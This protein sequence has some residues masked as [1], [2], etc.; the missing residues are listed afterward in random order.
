MANNFKFH[1]GNWRHGVS[2]STFDSEKLQEH[3]TK[4]STQSRLN[5]LVI[6]DS[7]VGKSTWINA[8][9]N[10]VT[11]EDLEEAKKM[12]LQYV[13]PLRFTAYNERREK[14]LIQIG[15]SENEGRIEG[16][17]ATQKPREHNF[18]H[19]GKKV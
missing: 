3:L 11:F 15:E 6:G 7:G 9:A 18:H 19:G 1:C 5:L 13:I 4:L 10:Y 16:Q 12:E 2:Y 8:F 17:S 14:M